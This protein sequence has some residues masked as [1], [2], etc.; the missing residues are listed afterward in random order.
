MPRPSNLGSHARAQQTT[1]P[2]KRKGCVRVAQKARG[3]PDHPLAPSRGSGALPATRPR[4]SDPSSHSRA[5]QITPPSEQK[6]CTRVAQ[7]ARGTLDR[8]LAPCRGSGA[9]PAALPRPSDLGSHTSG[10]GKQPL[11][12]NEKDVRG[13]NKKVRG[14]PDRPLAP[15]RGSGAPPA[16]KTKTSDL[17]PR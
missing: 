10:L 15:C 13:S 5:R 8:P 9:L 7:K 4:P 6:G 17:S 14:T 2:S 3:T 11:C 16:L 1:P 12:P